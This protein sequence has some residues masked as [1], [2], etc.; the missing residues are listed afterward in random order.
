V[1][2]K[3]CLVPA[4]ESCAAGL[5]AALDAARN[6]P[7][8]ERAGVALRPLG[9]ND[10]AFV[11]GWD[12]DP[13]LRRLF[14]APPSRLLLEEPRFLLGIEWFGRLVGIIGLT[15]VSALNRSA[16]LEIVIGPR[17]ERGRGIGRR[18]VRA[19]LELVF[20]LAGIDTIYLRVLAGNRR[21]VRCF[22]RCGFR[23]A[24]VL[25]VKNDPRYTHPPLDDDVLLM[26]LGRNQ[27]PAGLA[28]RSKAPARSRG[29][30]YQGPACEGPVAARNAP[31]PGVS[32]RSA[33]T[34]A[35]TQ[36]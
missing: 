19:Y 35:K 15:G 10:R 21:A 30:V 12:G 3:T 18:A 9:P 36:V 5:P 32:A 24:A 28:S 1:E 31:G 8:S 17:S 6:P 25:R 7:V 27:G 23:P 13:E 26:V 2:G 4:R 20:R 16:E 29:P 22:Q 11:A 33:L 34:P 14:G